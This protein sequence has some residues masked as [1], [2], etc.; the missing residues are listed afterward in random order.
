M[1][2]S[3][4]A[5]LA[6]WSILCRKACPCWAE[7]RRIPSQVLPFASFGL[8]S[9][10]KWSIH[11]CR[12]GI[13]MTDSWVRLEKACNGEWWFGNKCT[14]SGYTRLLGGAKYS[15]IERIDELGD[16][17]SISENQKI[18]LVCERIFF[19]F[20]FILIL[21]WSKQTHWP[22]CCLITRQSTLSFSIA[23]RLK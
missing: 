19:S 15:H 22:S 23:W 6:P 2:G 5:V 3:M 20:D 21:L 12:V 10:Q 1:L 7:A 4:E 9:D 16:H 14:V 11:T 17:K 8:M 13:V 18:K